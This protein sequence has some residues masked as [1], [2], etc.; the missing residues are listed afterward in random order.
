M[1]TPRAVHMKNINLKIQLNIQLRKATYEQWNN[2]TEKRRNVELTRFLI[3]FWSKCI[4]LR[5]RQCRSFHN[6]PF[7]NLEKGT[8]E[9]A[10]HSYSLGKS[11]N[12]ENPLC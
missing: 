2:G 9:S 12:L 7:R 10:A 4:A 8:D 6:R 3:K 1:T 5:K 11:R